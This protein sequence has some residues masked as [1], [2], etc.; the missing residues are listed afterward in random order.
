MQKG[1]H[2]QSDMMQLMEYLLERLTSAEIDLFWT[3]AWFI[4]SQRNC[5]V[6]GGRIK[7]PTSLN[8]RAVEYVEVHKQAQTH[9]T[10]SLMLQPSTE[11]WQPLPQ[12]AYKFNFDAAVFLGLN[13]SGFGAIIRND[14][15][16]VMA[17][18]TAS[19]PKVSTSDEAEML[20]C[21]RA[22]EFAVDAGFS[23]LIIEGDNVNVMQAISS[24]LANH[25]LIGNVVD[26][27]H[28]LIQGLQWANI[29]CIRRRGNK[30]A[31][32]LAQY[33]R[34]TLDDGLYWMED[35]PH[36]KWKFCI[37]KPY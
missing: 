14:K 16:E 36:Q 21:K 27:I 7:D 1:W 32:A 2:V 33:A 31:H 13:R 15:G 25:S 20:A 9:F 5:V 3:Q 24:P 8:K 26:D 23:R 17:A 28:H 29:C 19:R 12:T 30:V 22:L 6:H 4:W 35:S 11:A 37:K 34:N 18:M 10:V